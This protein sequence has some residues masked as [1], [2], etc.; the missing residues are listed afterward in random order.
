MSTSGKGKGRDPSPTGSIVTTATEAP[1]KEEAP[2]VA[3]PDLFYGDRKKFKAYCTQAR[4]YIWADERRKLKNR[5]IK[6]VVEQVMWAASYLRGDAYA[7]FEPYVSHYLDKGTAGACDPQGSKVITNF[8]EYIALLNQSYGDFD[9]AR[10]A[11]LRLQETKQTGSV[12]E[13]LTRF[14]QHASRVSWDDRAKMA[15]FYQGLKA[16]IKDAMAL[17]E[18]PTTMEELIQKSTRIDDNYRRRRQEKK[19]QDAGNRF[20]KQKPRTQRSPDEMDWEASVATHKKRTPKTPTGPK[21][22][23]G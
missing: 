19:G 6:T 13:Y 8:Q 3:E 21:K 7:R 11:E 23:K 18:F 15:Q 10:T 17:S 14:T 9:E 12:P 5:K 22:D 1:L 2:K 20:Q 4:L 16:E